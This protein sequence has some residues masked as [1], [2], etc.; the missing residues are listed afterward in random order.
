M[1]DQEARKGTKSSHHGGTENTE[2]YLPPCSPCLRG[3][4]NPLSARLHAKTALPLGAFCLL[5]VGAVA[6]ALPFLWMVSTSF[7][8]P[9]K[10][11]ALP[12]QWIPD[13]WR[14]ENY[15]EALTRL[16]FALY[17]RNTLIITFLSLVGQVGSSAL[18]A[19][20]FARL[21]FFGRDPLFFLMLSTMMLPPI[22][23]LIPTY[24][25]YVKLGW[26]NTFLPLVLPAFFGGGAFYIFLLRQFF[27]TIP[28]ELE[29]AARIDGSGSF[30]IFWRVFLPLSKPALATVAIFSF[31][32]HWNDFLSPL[33]YLRTQER[34][35]LALGLQTFQGVYSTHY[36]WLMAASIVVVL[37]VLVLFFACQRFFVQ[38]IVLTGLKG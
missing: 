2:K 3:K 36:E 21:R 23:T 26:V 13:P 5:C 38:G 25:M 6:F 7:K 27:L 31:I 12:P 22:A 32:G 10:V 33:I 15:R 16:P 19:F 37:P 1:I 8:A 14:P 29:D 30:G 18:V 17:L 20:G 28:K 34:F 4:Q 11:M 35:T 9:D 24:V